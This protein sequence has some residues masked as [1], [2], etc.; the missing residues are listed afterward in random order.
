MQVQG[1]NPT[2]VVSIP[3][4]E[5]VSLLYCP[6][7][8]IDC[9][10]SGNVNTCQQTK[11]SEGH[12]T[13]ERTEKFGCFHQPSDVDPR[14]ET[15]IKGN[16]C[17]QSLCESDEAS[18]DG[19]QSELL[20]ELQQMYDGIRHGD[21]D[22]AAHNIILTEIVKIVARQ[23]EVELSSPQGHKLSCT[24]ERQ[25]W[26]AHKEGRI[27]RWTLEGEDVEESLHTIS[28]SEIMVG[29]ESGQLCYR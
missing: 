2:E 13:C 9:H 8:G 29:L 15:S 17:M 22:M 25:I 5:V 7:D 26:K 12:Y 6:K 18:L 20:A 11:K 10:N 23:L 4:T 3:E 16:I 14:I 24:W 19:T 1:Y 27:A 28:D 21:A